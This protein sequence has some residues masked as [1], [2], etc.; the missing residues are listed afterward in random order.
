LGSFCQVHLFGRKLWVFSWLIC[1]FG[2]C[3]ILHALVVTACGCSEN[4]LHVSSIPSM[5]QDVPPPTKRTVLSETRSLWFGNKD[6][7]VDGPRTHICFHVQE[8]LLLYTTAQEQLLAF[9]VKI[10][11]QLVI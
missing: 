9:T 8:H 6:V 3:S 2:S 5:N 10:R 4:S 1:H 7:M 11:S